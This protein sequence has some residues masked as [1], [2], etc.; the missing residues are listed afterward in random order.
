MVQGL[1]LKIYTYYHQYYLLIHS[2]RVL[3]DLKDVSVKLAG[4]G[5]VLPTFN[6]VF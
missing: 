6:F 4:F 1:R 2:G 5:F 3:R